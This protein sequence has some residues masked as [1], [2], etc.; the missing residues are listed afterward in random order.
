MKTNPLVLL[1]FSDGDLAS[2]LVQNLK[3]QDLNFSI[4]ETAHDVVE[5]VTRRFFHIVL[6]DVSLPDNVGIEV[7]KQ[8]KSTSPDTE[9]ILFTEPGTPDDFA[10]QAIADGAYDILEKPINFE[11][12]RVLISKA[13]ETQKLKLQSIRRLA[14]VE[15]LLS[16]TEDI[17]SQLDMK[18]LLRQLVKRALA[19][20][21][22]ECG[23]IALFGNDKVIMR[24]FWDGKNWQD[25]SD[26]GN[27]EMDNFQEFWK[28]KNIYV[29]DEPGAKEG[30]DIFFQP[31]PWANSYV[32]VPIVG[33]KNE[34]LGV[35]EVCNKKIADFGPDDDAQLLEGLARTASIAIENAK[36]YEY[37][38]WKS[39]KLKE[40]EQKYRVLVENS[41]DLVF[42]I[43]NHRVKYANRKASH[44]LSYKPEELHSFNIV[45]IIAPGY[46][47]LFMEN[48]KKKAKGEEVP[49]YEVVLVNKN[50]EEVVL[51]VNGVLTEYEGKPA[52]QII[53][54]DITDRRKADKEILRL[55][56]AVRSLNSAVTITDMNRNIIY[57]NPVHKRVFG[58]ELEELMGKQSS[59][60]YPFDDPSGVSKK[61]YEAILIVGWEGERLGMRKNGEVFPVYEK[62]SVVKDKD[63]K[64]IGIVSV[65]E[66]I[67]LRKRLEQALKESE[68]RYRT[69]VETAKTAII[70][71]DEEGKIVL[72]NPSAV[73]LFGYTKE[74]IENKEF[75]ILTPERY[76][77]FYKIG[78]EN[79]LGTDVSNLLGKTMEIA[80]L[81]KS[82]EEFPIEVSLS[83]CRIGGRQIL[84]AIIFDITERKNLQEQL[85]QS[86]KL[87]AVGELIAGVT[88]EVNNPLAVVMGYSEMILGEENLDPQLR[89]SI[90]VIYNEAN[91]ARKVIQNLL[92]FARGHSPEKQ[93][94]SINEIME[95]T[96]SLTEYDL[97]KN[98]IEVVKR[99]DPDLPGTMADPNQ[100]QQ[101]FLN[102]IIN[103]EQAMS[104]NAG[105]KQ[106]IIESRVK[107]GQS[108]I[109][110]DVGS[111][112]ELSFHDNG[113]GITEKH[114]KKIFDPFFTTKPV[115]KGTGLGLSVSYGIIKEHGGEIY[116]HSKEGEGATFFIELP[117]VYETR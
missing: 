82:G 2:G 11:Y 8:I 59:I 115:G 87:A 67:T 100:L 108:R 32:C 70:A 85:I 79:F 52:V 96:L 20:T 1:G 48:L 25:I 62:T 14:Q 116:A 3:G 113:P 80:G 83:A 65:V 68:E 37:T 60:L 106:L 109:N 49:N 41:P 114:L 12:V 53:G 43:Q 51:D 36:L 117:V 105:K 90:D 34:F 73:E 35:I 104:E 63:G 40:S 55:A 7:L 22:C 61:I 77:D 93:F 89:K 6:V 15:S 45:D 47:D 13:L 84:T 30:L 28:D 46:K 16:A 38:R 58:Y 95:K 74:E 112:I 10:I 107:N 64:Q 39:E 75:N 18:Q 99:F 31:L 17:N 92:S 91:R 5:S 97:R 98:N 94:T 21:G 50:G 86:A 102:L 101:V 24:E 26:S 72:F 78:L 19:L 23:A 33:R 56:A 57:I 103:A 81:K 42:I 54:R 9:V 27:V 4:A 66:E 44:L 29:S 76:K 69:L 71:I 88:H 111:V 110:T